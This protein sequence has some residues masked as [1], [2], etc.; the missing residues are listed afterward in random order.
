CLKFLFVPPNLCVV[1]IAVASFAWCN[2]FYI[3]KRAV[4][5]Q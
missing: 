2:L 5:L 1:T 4:Q 3:F